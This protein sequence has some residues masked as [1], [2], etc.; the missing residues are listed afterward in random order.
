MTGKNEAP[1]PDEWTSDGNTRI[2]GQVIDDADQYAHNEEGVFTWR[3]VTE[4]VVE[5]LQRDGYYGGE[6]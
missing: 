5:K 6:N 1:D 4:A 2:D 3:Y